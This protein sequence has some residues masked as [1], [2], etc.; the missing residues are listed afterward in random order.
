MA[1]TSGGIYFSSPDAAGVVID[2]TA[3]GEVVRAADVILLA[4]YAGNTLA[5]IGQK[6][7]ALT[8]SAALAAVENDVLAE[9]IAGDEASGVRVEPADASAPVRFFA[10]LHHL[11]A[12]DDNVFGL[13]SQRDWR[14]KLTCPWRQQRHGNH[15]FSTSIVLLY[16]HLLKSRGADEAQRGRLRRTMQLVAELH[17]AGALRLP[18]QWADASMAAAR[19]GWSSEA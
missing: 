6:D 2:S 14:I 11:D 7:W 16:H 4:L 12:V 1:E 3:N 17:H 9:F 15:Y 13:R 5:D 18:S 10:T 19:L 8:F